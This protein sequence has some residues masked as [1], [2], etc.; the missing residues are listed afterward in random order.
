MYVR[1]IMTTHVITVLDTMCFTDAA[2]MFLAYQL[3]GAP[4]VN[5]QNE[6]V[7]ILSEKD[8]LRA[9]YPTYEN[10]YVDPNYLLNDEALE[11]I[12]A[13]AEEKQ[14]SEI[15]SHRVI[16]TTPDTHILKIGG[17]MV[18]TGIHKV[19]VVDERK[20]LIGM[21]SRHDVYRAMLEKAFHIHTIGD[22]CR[23]THFHA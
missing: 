10:F 13:S 20:R 15:M 22:A 1:N 4:V 5:T 3:S 16:M 18:A 21:V 14:V 11:S 12:A 9:M 6:L 19:P 2:K 23:S 8:L 7:G 17:Q